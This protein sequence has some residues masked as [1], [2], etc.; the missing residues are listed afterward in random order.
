M[1]ALV[2]LVVLETTKFEYEILEHIGAGG[3]GQVFKVRRN[4]Q[5]MACKQIQTDNLDFALEEHRHMSVV[6]GGPHIA[7]VHHDV[8]WNPHTRTLSFFMDYYE[9]KDLDR[10]IHILLAMGGQFTEIQIIEIAYQIAV[11]IEYCHDNGILHQDLKPKNVLLDCHWNPITEPD[12]VPELFVT[13]FGFA[14]HV[15]TMRTRISGQR[16]TPGYQA[17]EISDQG[18]HAAVS[19][20][21]DI[22]AFG[23]I[24]YR[25]STLCQPDE[26]TGIKPSEISENLSIELLSLISLM[27]SEN[28]EDRPTAANVKH[29]LECLIRI[30]MPTDA[31]ECLVCRKFFAS[32]SALQK[33]IKRTGHS[34]RR[35]K[36]KNVEQNKFRSSC[37][38]PPLVTS[39]HL[40]EPEFTIRGAAT[41][42]LV[43]PKGFVISTS[44]LDAKQGNGFVIK[45]IAEAMSNRPVTPADEYDPCAV[46]FRDFDKCNEFWRHLNLKRHA[47]RRTVVHKLLT[48]RGIQP[49]AS[50]SKRH[51]HAQ[52]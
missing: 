50:V 16:G 32:K 18:R 35:N 23:C 2:S 25:L 44:D 33:H 22:Y 51:S 52:G 24:L 37:G 6:K 39:T 10:I 14:S 49:K 21:S 30:H 19:D 46:C 12:N 48:K 29:D 26:I 3:F 40:L 36:Q 17:P 43:I 15:Q 11:G 7:V 45:G 42:N 47:R 31:K 9:G 20:K 41:R 13:D 27:L 5:I 34:L 8:E 4:G 1:A 28:R 38:A